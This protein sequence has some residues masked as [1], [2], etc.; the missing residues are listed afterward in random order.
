MLHPFLDLY[1]SSWTPV[2]QPRTI[3]DQKKI[4]IALRGTPH[5]ALCLQQNTQFSSP[6]IKLMLSC[7]FLMFG[8]EQK[9]SNCKA[10]ERTQG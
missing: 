4:F 10:V 9:Q 5:L 3:I 7:T 8:R 2:V 6:L 1:F